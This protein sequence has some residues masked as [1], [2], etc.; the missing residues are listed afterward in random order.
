[1][2]YYLTVQWFAMCIIFIAKNAHP[3]HSLIIAANRDEYFE[4]PTQAPHWW[5][6]APHVYAGKDLKAGGTWMGH[7]RNQ[8]IAAITNVRRL[9]LHKD[10]A[11]SRG[12]WVKRFLD[13]ESTD[14]ESV[15]QEFTQ[16]L[17]QESHHYNP[18]NLLY[19]N[20][21]HLMVF[22]S[23]NQQSYILSDGIYSISNGMLDTMWPK[24]QQGV[25]ALSKYLDTHATVI[26]ADL[27]D[28]L[29]N[30]DEAPEDA[31]PDTGIPEDYEKILSSIFIRP[32]LFHGAVYGTRSSSVIYSESQKGS[33]D[34]NNHIL[35]ASET[36]YRA[37]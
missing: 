3:T 25:S 21:Q 37:G 14:I 36:L 31:L 16:T 8:H 30:D 17:K 27:F 11:R 35:R 34:N 26:P 15:V 1:M 10:D 33:N 5:P 4:R 13:I 22:N 7:N 18:F 9:D 12:E 6:D 24:M 23:V 20:S 28:L 32:S 19:G 2:A 29:Q